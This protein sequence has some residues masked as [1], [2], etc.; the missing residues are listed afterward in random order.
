MYLVNYVYWGYGKKSHGSTTNLF[1][2]I[3]LYNPEWVFAN[4]TTSF[5]CSLLHAHVF[6][7]LIFKTRRSCRTLSSQF[8]LGRP[9]GLD[10]DDFQ[11]VIFFVVL[12]SCNLSRC[13][14]HAS[15]KSLSSY[16]PYNIS[17]FQKNVYFFVCCPSSQTVW[18]TDLIIH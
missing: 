17:L 12:S 6:Q 10:D 2:L 9:L 16:I 8:F 13:L 7:T 14:N 11:T 5:H 4:S 3:L 1:A 15:C 18:P